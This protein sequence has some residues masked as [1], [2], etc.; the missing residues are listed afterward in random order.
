M[1]GY[2]FKILD[3]C[4]VNSYYQVAH[5]KFTYIIQKSNGLIEGEKHTCWKNTAK[6]LWCLENSL[7]KSIQ[8]RKPIHMFCPLPRQG[9]T[10][11]S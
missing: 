7:W 10:D 1:G 11:V 2:S 6:F 9:W 3:S 4:N 5:G 8:W